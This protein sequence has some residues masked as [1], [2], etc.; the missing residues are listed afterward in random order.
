MKLPIAYNLRNLVVRKTT[1]LMTTL[2]IALTVAVL[3]ADLALVNG[4]RTAFQASGNPLQILVLRKGSSSEVGSGIPRQVYQDLRFKS[5]IARNSSS[6]PMASLEVVTVINLPSIDSPQGMNVTLRGLMPLG[7]DMREVA[8]REGRWFRAGQ[9][10]VVVGRSVAK[11]YPGRAWANSFGSGV[12][13]GKWWA[14]SMEANLP[15][16]ARS[17]VI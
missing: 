3:V 9:R 1:T 4:L 12:V 6:E 8:V 17:G 11:R 16:T 10:E 15:S 13:S 7:I 2:G 14:C 5:G